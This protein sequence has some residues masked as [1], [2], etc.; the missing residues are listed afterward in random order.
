MDRRNFITTASFGASALAIPHLVNAKA[1]PKKEPTTDT[2]NNFWP[3]GSRLAISIALQFEAGGQPISGAAGLIPEPIK[4][5]YPDL[6][7]NSYFDY[8]VQEGIPRLLDLFDKYGV[9]ATSFMV[10]KAV[11]NNPELAREIVR[12]GHEPAAHGKEWAWQYHLS[13]DEEREWI[14]SVKESIEKATGVTPLGYDCYWMRGSVH[15]LS[16]LQELGFIYHNNDLSRDEPYIQQLNDKPFV[17]M[18][19]TIHMNDIGSYDF[20]G[21]SPADYEQQ[22]KD[23]FDQL[24][25]ESATRRRMMLISFHDRISGHASRVRVIERFFKYVAQHSGVWYATKAELA[26]HALATPNITPLVT[27]DVAEKSGLAGNTNL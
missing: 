24:Y 3:N 21:F 8:G 16:L 20:S 23:E 22:L 13:K 6:A 12:R 17:T 27:R 11:D 25:E 26:Q 10:G 1:S 18:P 14:R 9:K 4:K 15:T 7:T 2:A 5:D 19:Y